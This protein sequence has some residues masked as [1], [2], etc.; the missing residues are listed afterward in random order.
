M[1]K[2]LAPP[3]HLRFDA[4]LA[5]CLAHLLQLTLAAPFSKVQLL[6]RL[7]LNG[8]TQ[9]RQAGRQAGRQVQ[10]E[11]LNEVGAYSLLLPGG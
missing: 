11:S 5:C 9:A 6:E 10:Q 8:R 2:G 1:V 3:A 4:Q 7:H